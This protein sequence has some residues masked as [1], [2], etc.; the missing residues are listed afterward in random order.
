MAYKFLGRFEAR[1]IDHMV[2]EGE[3]FVRTQRAIKVTDAD[4]DG[5]LVG[6]FSTL[7]QVR[8]AIIEYLLYKCEVPDSAREDLYRMTFAQLRTYLRVKQIEA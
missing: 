2:M 1:A 8:W 7:R 6:I 5:E 4:H 3:R